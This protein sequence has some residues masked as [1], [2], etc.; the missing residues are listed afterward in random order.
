MSG[1]ASLEACAP[2]EMLVDVRESES[3][4]KQTITECPSA[5]ITVALACTTQTQNL[6]QKPPQFSK[7][8]VATTPTK[9]TGI[10]IFAFLPLQ[11]A[12]RITINEKPKEFAMAALTGADKI[13]AQDLGFGRGTSIARETNV[14]KVE[15]QAKRVFQRP[16]IVSSDPAWYQANGQTNSHNNGHNNGQTNGRVRS[17]LSPTAP[18]FV[19]KGMPGKTVAPRVSA[20]TPYAWAPTATSA[21]LHGFS[22]YFENRESFARFRRGLVHLSINSSLEPEMLAEFLEFKRASSIARQEEMLEKSSNLTKDKVHIVGPFNG[23]V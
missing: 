10:K 18:G 19:P 1:G 22:P 12:Q 13:E 15:E 11:M 2:D 17:K 4:G 9:R 16:A 20:S 7:P 14:V 23:K 21:S 6:S 3:K 5:R 8:T